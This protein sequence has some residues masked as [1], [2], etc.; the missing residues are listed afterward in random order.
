MHKGIDTSRWQGSKVD[1]AAAK[2]AGYEFVILRIGA[3]KNKDAT[4]EKDFEAAKKAGLKVGVY[5]YTYADSVPGATLD[6]TRVLGWLNNRHLDLPVFYDMEDKTQ[7]GIDRRG[8]NAAMICEFTATVRK[9]GYGC[10][11]YT[12][13]YFFNH[14]IDTSFVDCGLW[15]AKYSNNK[16]YVGRDIALWQYTSDAIP[17]DFYSGKLDRSYC[18]VDAWFGTTTAAQIAEDEGVN[19][20]PIPTRVL[21]KTIPCMKGNDVRWLQYELDI[22]IDGVFGPKTQKAVISFQQHHHD[23][24]VVDGKVGEATRYMLINS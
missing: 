18:Y 24:L 8:L 11:L 22:D 3:G 6:A 2:K 21:K 16:P 19:P 17:G 15:I 7:K 14:Y 10:M 20:Y 4:F 12:G 1:Y 9:G 5:L 13:E 23:K